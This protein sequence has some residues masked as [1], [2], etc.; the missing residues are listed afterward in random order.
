MSATMHPYPDTLAVAVATPTSVVTEPLPA[1][2]YERVS[3]LLG[4][5][6][7]SQTQ[8]YAH[9]APVKAQDVAASL[10]DPRAANVAQTPIADGVTGLR[11]V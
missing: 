7:I 6:S 4:H 11:A 8:I 9:L 1:A 2:R 3:E 5:S 10:I